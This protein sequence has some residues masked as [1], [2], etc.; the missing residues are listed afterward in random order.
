MCGPPLPSLLPAQLRT[1]ILPSPLPPSRSA[2]RETYMAKLVEVTAQLAEM[3][4]GRKE[5]ER[6]RQH[7]E[8]VAQLTRVIKGG[9]TEW[10]AGRRGATGWRAAGWGAAGGRGGLVQGLLVGGQLMSHRN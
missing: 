6:D 7:R 5:D 8:S 9:W 1:L 2:R 4:A 10:R 3:R